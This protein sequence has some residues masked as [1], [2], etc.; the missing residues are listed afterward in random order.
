[1]TKHAFILANPRFINNALVLLAAK[2]LVSLDAFKF[3][4]DAARLS[5][6]AIPG[7]Q[8]ERKA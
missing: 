8:L 7:I 2:L 5:K 6:F 3:W 4:H 1:M